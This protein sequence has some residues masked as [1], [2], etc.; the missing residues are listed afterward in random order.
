M[1]A[2]AVR[3]IAAAASALCVATFWLLALAVNRILADSIIDPSA[4]IAAGTVIA[5]AVHR[6]VRRM[7]R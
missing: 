1:T 5:L 6:A 2:L 3:M 4:G 7:L